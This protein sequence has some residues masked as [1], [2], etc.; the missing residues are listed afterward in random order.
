MENQANRIDATTIARLFHTVA[1]DDKSIKISHKTLL[2]VSE[3]IRLFTSEAI[4]RSNVERLEE[5]Q[6][7]TERYRV[8]VDDRA[9]EKQQDAVLDT[10]HLEAVAGLLTLDF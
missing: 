10:R 5:R 8:D 9:D 3:Y 2:L 4:V 7:D 1:F 6:R